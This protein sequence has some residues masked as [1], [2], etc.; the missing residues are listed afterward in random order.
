MINS[1]EEAIRK[2]LAGLRGCDVSLE[3]EQRVLK[4][5]DDQASAESQSGR[6][7]RHLTLPSM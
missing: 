4:A 3:M 2:V 5:V 1:S 7:S 6:W